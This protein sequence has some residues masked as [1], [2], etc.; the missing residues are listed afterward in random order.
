MQTFLPL[1]VLFSFLIT[2]PKPAAV[3]PLHNYSLSFAGAALSRPLANWHSLA[4]APSLSVSARSLRNVYFFLCWS[5]ALAVSVAVAAA[6][7]R[8]VS[9]SV[10]V[11]V[12]L[13]LP[14]LSRCLQ[15]CSGYIRNVLLLLQLVAFETLSSF[16]MLAKHFSSRIQAKFYNN[17]VCAF[18][19][20]CAC[21][22][23]K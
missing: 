1:L 21:C 4:R 11:S 3:L 6:A 8:W 15:L 5:L 18:P 22:V 19:T 7:A 23:C 2:A 13:L 20:H 10:S 12:A 9:V 14:L 17:F 16:V